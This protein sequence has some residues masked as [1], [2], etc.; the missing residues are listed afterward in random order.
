MR[1]ASKTF[2]GGTEFPLPGWET[3]RLKT[4]SRWQM[5]VLQEPLHRFRT[6]LT[7]R[8]IPPIV[9]KICPLFEL[10]AIRD[11]LLDPPLPSR[12][13]ARDARRQPACRARNC[14][15]RGVVA[16]RRGGNLG[17]GRPGWH[18]PRPHV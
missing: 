8:R 15:L 3:I 12:L 16:G 7:L 14:R 4:C 5:D 17:G 18:T 6:V 9:A 11:A 10:G 1:E 13:P 2:I